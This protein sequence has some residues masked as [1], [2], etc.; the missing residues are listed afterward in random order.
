MANV[1]VTT[2][3]KHIGEVWPKDIIRAQEFKLVIAPRVYRDWKFAG[4]GDVYHVARF[5]NLTVNSKSAGSA[6]TP[7][8]LTDTE[9][10]ITIN[11]HQVAGVEIESI[12][13]LLSNNDLARENRRTI[14][15]AL[16][17]ALD[18]NLATLP[19]NFSQ[20]VGTLG[21]ETV[22]DELVDA[23]NYLADTGIE[24]QDNCTWFLSPGAV[25]GLLK[26]DIILSQLYQSSDTP[27]AAQSARV[28]QILG[29]P[30]LMSNL[31]RAPSAGQSES[32]LVYKQ[33]MALIMAQEPKMVAEVIA[34]NLAEVI[35]GHQIYGYAEVDRYS[36]TPANVTATDEWAVL[37]N[38]KA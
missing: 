23:W 1:T 26:Q 28:G 5:P 6:W 33:A 17:R 18:V 14:G 21:S 11:V 8:A 13:A 20:S 32:F 10:T 29:A 30:V 9:Q 31:T 4:W 22:Y 15:Y 35:G 37:V 19:Q 3:A 16:G 24:L 36:E 7:E 25:G 34:L 38:T 2:A 12:A 27:T